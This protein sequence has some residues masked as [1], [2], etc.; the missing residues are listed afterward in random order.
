MENGIALFPVSDEARGYCSDAP[1]PRLPRVLR[2]FFCNTQYVTLRYTAIW[3]TLGPTPAKQSVWS[4]PPTHPPQREI[5]GLSRKVRFR[6]Q[7]TADW[8]LLCPFVIS[9]FCICPSAFGALGVAGGVSAISVYGSQ[10]QQHG[11][12]VQ[13]GRVQ[14]GHQGKESTLHEFCNAQIVNFCNL[15]ALNALRICPKDITISHAG[16]I[17][18]GCLQN[19]TRVCYP[20]LSLLHRNAEDLSLCL[21]LLVS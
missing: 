15:R 10:H 20:P 12:R 14:H 6:K 21:F 13:H 16:E 9:V 17:L 7:T 3:W 4:T 19:W 5:I 2:W 11:H 8:S 18:P 1:V